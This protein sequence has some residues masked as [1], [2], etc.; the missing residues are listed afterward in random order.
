MRLSLENKTDVVGSV[1]EMLDTLKPG[2]A[3]TMTISRATSGA[4]FVT[5]VTDASSED[6]VRL[7]GVFYLDRLQS[8]Y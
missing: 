8:I 4:Y 2:S 6:I 3:L 7:L 5:T 1:V